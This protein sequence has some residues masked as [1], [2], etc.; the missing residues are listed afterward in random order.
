MYRK[1]QSKSSEIYKTVRG[2][3]YNSGKSNSRISVLISIKTCFYPIFPIFNQQN[4]FIN[5]HNMFINAHK[6]F[7]TRV[8][9]KNQFFR[10]I[11]FRPEIASAQIDI[12]SK[13]FHI[14]SARCQDF[15]LP[16][17]TTFFGRVLH[18]PGS[19]TRPA[20]PIRWAR[21]AENMFFCK[22]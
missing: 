9:A 10:R 6:M 12:F 15:Q 16:T 14:M 21:R 4:A 11:C 7:L 2:S 13:V 8:W 5:C 1:D 22:E 3:G 18:P 17:T 20:W 19:L